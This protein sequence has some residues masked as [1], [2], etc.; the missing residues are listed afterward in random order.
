MRYILIT[1]DSSEEEKYAARFW[2]LKGL[3]G[4][5]AAYTAGNHASVVAVGHYKTRDI[6]KACKLSLSKLKPVRTQENHSIEKAGKNKPVVALQ[7]R[8][9]AAVADKI[10]RCP[11]N[12]TSAHLT[13]QDACEDD[14]YA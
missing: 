11:N 3:S 6:L 1:A 7:S 8:V 13:K 12:L 10:V 2:K 9:P 14:V 5:I 4:A